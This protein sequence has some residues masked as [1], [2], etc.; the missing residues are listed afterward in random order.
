MAL[1]IVSDL[2]SSGP[3]WPRGQNFGLGLEAF[4]RLDFVV[5]LCNRA[6]FFRAKIVLN[7]G[8]LFFFSGSNLKSYL[9]IIIWYFFIFGLS[10]GLNLQKLASASGS[11]S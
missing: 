1:V 5:L 9:L 11:V 6:F 3:K 2:K 7:L 10:L 4:A 8:I